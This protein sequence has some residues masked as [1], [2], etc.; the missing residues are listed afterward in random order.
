M[1]NLEELK[2]TENHEWLR[3][4]GKRAYIGITDHAQEELGDIVFVELPEPDDQFS[5]GDEA[6]NIE[7]VKAAAPVY[8]PVSGKVSEVNEALEDAPETINEK[9]Y[10][11]HLFVL[12]VSD[13]SELDKLMDY[14][15][16][17]AFLEEE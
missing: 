7:S 3:L 16:Y 8:S 2:Y 17:Q 13:S 12:E 14:Q 6:V 10:E 9:P 11:T 15:A 1:S 5:Q 4:E